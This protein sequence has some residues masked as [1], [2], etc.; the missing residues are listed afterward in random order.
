M[1]KKLIERFAVE[2]LLPSLP[3]FCVRGNLIYE[4]PVGC[5]LRAFLFDSSGFSATTFYPHV[6][7]QALYI[8]FGHLTLTPG[9]RFPGHWEFLPDNEPELARKLLNQVHAMGLP[10]LRENST[11]EGLIREA[12]ANPAI[13]VNSRIRQQLAYS[14]VLLGRNDEGLDELDVLLAMINQ[15]SDP[16]PWERDLHTEIGTLREKLMRNPREVV[17]TLQQ[18]TEQ[19]RAKLNLPS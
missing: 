18:W 4:V 17:E 3:G 1:K 10:F 7:V 6:F 14:L 8:P 13:K 12:R 15:K 9:K 16:A 11:P 2:H 5:I 19:T